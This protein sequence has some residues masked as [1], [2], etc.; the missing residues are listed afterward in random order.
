MPSHQT[1]ADLL[2]EV[3]DEL[4]NI[5]RGGENFECVVDSIHAIR[6]ASTELKRRADQ[7]G[8]GRVATYRSAPDLVRTRAEGAVSARGPIP[9]HGRKP[10]LRNT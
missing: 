9:R 7:G 2:Q 8:Y 3:N 4:N 5:Y 1:N 10:R 6:K